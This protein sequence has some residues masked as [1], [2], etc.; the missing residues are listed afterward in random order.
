[1][2]RRNPVLQHWNLQD[3]RCIVKNGAQEPY[4]AA[5]ESAGQLQDSRCIVKNGAQEPHPVWA[6]K[7][8]KARGAW[9]QGKEEWHHGICGH[10][11]QHCRRGSV[12]K[13][14]HLGVLIRL[15][16]LLHFFTNYF[17][18]PGEDRQRKKVVK[19]LI[20]WPLLLSAAAI[21]IS[22]TFL[23]TLRHATNKFRQVVVL[24]PR[25]DFAI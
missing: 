21:C 7:N 25:L 18:V 17:S 15:L 20:Q 23:Q 9:G 1:M 11:L 3:S 14:G 4:L 24:L 16:F 13:R 10:V 5:L 2:E 22:F 8:L 19:I 6:F 12:C